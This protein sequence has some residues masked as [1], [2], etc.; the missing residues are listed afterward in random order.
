VKFTGT[1]PLACGRCGLKAVRI[2]LVSG[3]AWSSLAGL[4]GSAEAATRGMGAPYGWY[5]GWYAPP[6][7]VPARKVRVAPARKEKAEPKKDAGFGQM[8]KGPLQI[9]VSIGSQK[10]TLFSNGVRVAQGPV[11]TGVPGHPTPTGVFSII[12]KDRYHHSNLYSNAPMPYMQRITWSGVALHEGVLPGY[13]ASHGCIRMSHDFAQKLWP[14]TNLGARVIVTHHDLAPVEFAHPKLFA[15]RLKPPAPA[16]AMDGGSEG[17]GVAPA[18]VM[19]QATIPD[20]AIDAIDAPPP[21]E[22]TKPASDAT[23]DREAAEVAMPPAETM[24]PRE[25]VVATDAQPAQG[26]DEAKGSG[27]AE[28]IQSME[29]AAPVAPSDAGNAV[30]LPQRSEP[31][32]PAQMLPAVAEP[33]P[34]EA[35]PGGSD[36]FKPAP[37][38]DPAKPVAPPIKAADQPAKRTGQVAVFVSRKEQKIFVR[39][40]F[41]PLFDM[42]VVIDRPDQPLGTHVFTAMEVTD[43]GSG[44]RWNLMTVPTEASASTEQRDVRKKSK[45]APKETPNPAARLKRP[46]TAA[47]ALDRIQIPQEAV[48]RIG[49][50]LIPGSSLVVSDEGLGRET[51][52]YTEFIVLSR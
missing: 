39:Q 49:E 15:P 22:A 24:K 12:E 44:M 19:A 35:A 20:A 42:P 29:V 36:I 9:V 1:A 34:A 40:G 23:D 45:E 5:D 18:I 33:Q 37:T 6:A 16:I 51:G 26:S 21:A 41:V 8:P 50:L 43:N 46:V 14:I 17:R 7:A 52:R 25:D 27:L 30:E 31:A 2:A 11:S 38:D 10:V 4:A 13:P 28:F 32:T 3:V 48:D 47:Q